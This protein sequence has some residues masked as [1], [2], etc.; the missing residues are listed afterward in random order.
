MH[1]VPPEVAKVGLTE[2]YDVAETVDEGLLRTLDAVAERDSELTLDEHTCTIFLVIFV[3]ESARMD[4]K[5]VGQGSNDLRED[6]H[7]LVLTMM[8]GV[9][10]PIHENRLALGVLMHIEE[11]YDALAPIGI[12]LA[13]AEKASHR[14]YLWD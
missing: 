11:S 9:L 14:H 10:R 8:H 1:K 6:P 3:S 4:T 13:E 12:P 5:H 2:I 7:P